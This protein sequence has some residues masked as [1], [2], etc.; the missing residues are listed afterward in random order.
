[1]ICNI[2]PYG[3][4]VLALFTLETEFISEKV[5]KTEMEY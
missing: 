4:Q 2:T 5:M 3:K 1:M